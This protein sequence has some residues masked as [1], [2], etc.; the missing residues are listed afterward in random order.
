MR[1]RERIYPPNCTV[2]D[3]NPSRFLAFR[4]KQNEVE[5]EYGFRLCVPRRTP[6]QQDG[7]RRYMR[8]WQRRYRAA[9]REERKAYRHAYWVNV[10]KRGFDNLA[11]ATGD[12]ETLKRRAAK[13]VAKQK[14]AEFD[15]RKRQIHE[16]YGF[17]LNTPPRTP[18]EAAGRARYRKEQDAARKE[19]NRDKI[20]A[21][22]KEH[23][24]KRREENER[25][26]Q[27]KL[28]R[29]AAKD[30][31]AAEKLKARHEKLCFIQHMTHEERVRYRQ[32]KQ[33]ERLQAQAERER[34]RDEAKRRREERKAEEKRLRAPKVEKP[35]LSKL[36]MMRLEQ[37]ERRKERE[38][39]EAALA[40]SEREA[41]AA[42]VAEREANRAAYLAAKAAMRERGTGN[43]EQAGALDASLTRFS[44]LREE[45]P[46]APVPAVS[47][48]PSVP[49][50]NVADYLPSHPFRGLLLEDTAPTDEELAGEVTSPVWADYATDEGVNQLP[51]TGGGSTPID[52]PTGNR[53][54]NG[55]S[56]DDDDDWRRREREEK[57]R[58]VQEQYGFTLGKKPVTPEEIEGKK[59]YTADRARETAIRNREI[60]FMLHGKERV[61][62]AAAKK[63]KATIARKKREAAAQAAREAKAA[64]REALRKEREAAR[65]AAR[66]A[67]EEAIEALAAAKVERKALL[68]QAYTTFSYK[69]RAWEGKKEKMRR[70]LGLPKMKR[71]FTAEQRE[72]WNTYLREGRKE[73]ENWLVER[74]RKELAKSRKKD[75][76]AERQQSI[77]ETLATREQRKQER[78]VRKRLIFEKYGFT[79]GKKPTTPEEIE[80]FKRWQ[81]DQDAEYRKRH[82]D[83]ITAYNR[84]YR[85]RKRAEA[86]AKLQTTWTR[87]QWAEWE[88]RELAKACPPGSLQWMVREVVKRIAAEQNLPDD[89]VMERVIELGGL[90]FIIKGAESMGQKRCNRPSAVVAAARALAFYLDPDKAEMFGEQRE[91]EI[92]KREEH[93]G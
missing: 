53:T 8:D 72:L 40:A 88:K 29:L 67:R 52:P 81:R 64:E 33:Y 71:D 46:V 4:A 87:K 68:E 16:Q 49:V 77:A 61:R 14:R 56:E 32:Q 54:T 57:I 69:V 18:E 47:P 48:V 90:D 23:N 83:R 19:R 58:R 11:E 73:L 5:A 45:P 86:L 24:A 3:L 10:T 84:E 36:Q 70:S 89:A 92:G 66:V 44:E 12:E 21:Y 26:F 6:E 17:W 39:A 76:A 27:A 41:R 15:E 20:A 13:K 42:F 93:K 78:E 85:R 2:C 31:V 35:R 51:A 34:R 65:Q 25:K 9:H 38:A 91:E 43:G 1:R 7:Y 60:D 62:K 80:G 55:G 50:I 30:P 75:R 79:L 74:M 59:R 82:H 37:A 28:K 63:R 22:Q